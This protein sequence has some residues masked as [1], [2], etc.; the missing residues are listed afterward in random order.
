MTMLQLGDTNSLHFFFFYQITQKGTIDGMTLLSTTMD[1][2]MLN[3]F[4]GHFTGPMAAMVKSEP[5]ESNVSEVIFVL[6]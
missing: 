3:H 6:V 1:L 5:L 2:I 4:T